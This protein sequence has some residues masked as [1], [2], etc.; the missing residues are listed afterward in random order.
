M[1]LFVSPP[2]EISRILTPNIPKAMKARPSL[3]DLTRVHWAMIAVLGVLAM[4]LLLLA[5]M[6][7]EVSRSASVGQVVPGERAAIGAR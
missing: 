3:D 4:V 5:E 2:C 7:G 6:L 1:R